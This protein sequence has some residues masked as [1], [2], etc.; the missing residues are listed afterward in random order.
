MQ[1]QSNA[2]MEFHKKKVLDREGNPDSDQISLL[3]NDGSLTDKP[4]EVANI[5]NDF[6]IS[7]GRDLVNS[8]P[9]STSNFKQYFQY[10]DNCRKE[11]PKFTFSQID[12]RSNAYYRRSQS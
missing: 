12:T 10:T 11:Q 3:R 2:Q 8:L 1:E 6:F 9:P 4:V 5:F 7:V